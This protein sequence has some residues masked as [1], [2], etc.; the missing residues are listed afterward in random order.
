M[1]IKVPGGVTAAEGFQ[2]SGVPAGI[3]YKNKR[4]VALVYSMFEAAVAGVFTTN[5]VKAAPILLNINRLSVSGTAKAVII[6]SGNANACTGDRGMVDALAMTEETARLL[7]IPKEQVFVA[8]TGVI[9]QPMPM[10]RIIRGVAMA[11]NDLSDNGGQDAAEA[12]M[13]TDTTLKQYALTFE[14]E[15]RKVTI[16]GMAKGSGMIHPNM[17]TMLGFI[18][19]D[20]SISSECLDRC[21]HQAN[22]KSFNM[23]TV[24]GDTSTNDMVMVL[25]NGQAGNNKIIDF[26][27]EGYRIFSEAL[28]EICVYLAKEVA[29]D[30][31]GASKFIQVRVVNALNDKDAGLAARSIAGSSLFKAA[32][33]GGDANWGRIMCAAGYSG[34]KFN[35]EKFDVYLGGV[36]VA[37][38]GGAL[39]FDEE[40]AAE[41]LAGKE[42]EVLVDLIEG[43]CEATAWGCD[44][45][46]EYVK[47]NGNYRS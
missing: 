47:I 37:K 10:D 43:T 40:N 34:A 30:G 27:S 11:V 21:L 24:D 23:I 44:L 41:V 18:T 22:A 2:A 15:G 32:V 14:L 29:R 42:I 39:D 35:P 25:A 16:G 3:K 17:A 5:V 7:G 33:F 1:F 20:A 45:T 36:Q 46:Y 13:T 4:D 12:I 19:T 38:D 28:A 9:G 8:S 6:N 31:E 26:D